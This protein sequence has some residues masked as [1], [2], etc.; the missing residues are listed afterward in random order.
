MQSKV[1]VII[2]SWGADISLLQRN[3]WIWEIMSEGERY[4]VIV[5]TNDRSVNEWCAGRGVDVVSVT[6]QEALEAESFLPYGWVSAM[7]CAQTKGPLLLLDGARLGL[8]KVAIERKL[9][10]LLCN[11]T[12]GM[13]IGPVIDHPAQSEAYYSTRI[14]DFFVLPESRVPEALEVLVGEQ[15]SPLWLSKAV[16]LDFGYF[17]VEDGPGALYSVD[18]VQGDSLQYLGGMTFATFRRIKSLGDGDAVVLYCPREGMCQRIFRC[19]ESASHSILSPV[20][21]NRSDVTLSLEKGGGIRAVMIMPEIVTQLA[22]HVY[23][24]RSTGM[25]DLG[26]VPFEIEYTKTGWH[27]SGHWGHSSED[28]GYVFH[29]YRPEDGGSVDFCE[30]VF[31]SQGL[32]K[33]DAKQSANTNG[34][35]KLAIKGRQDLPELYGLDGAFV[36]APTGHVDDFMT[37]YAEGQVKAVKLEISGESTCCP[38]IMDSECFEEE[39]SVASSS[40]SLEDA[41]NGVL[42]EYRIQNTTAVQQL[43]WNYEEEC[44]RAI[45]KQASQ[46]DS[47]WFV[48]YRC[49]FDNDVLSRAALNQRFRNMGEVRKL[50]AIR[51]KIRRFRLSVLSER[52][53][54]LIKAGKEMDILSLVAKELHA[55][56][57]DYR[58]DLSVIM[59][60][61]I[62][63]S[64]ESDEVVRLFWEATKIEHL[65]TLVHKEMGMSLGLTTD[66]NTGTLY[67]A[68]HDNGTVHE[69]SHNGEYGGVLISGLGRPKALGFYRDLVWICDFDR[70]LLV[71]VDRLGE[72]RNTYDLHILDPHFSHPVSLSICDGKAAVL[73]TNAKNQGRVL[74]YVDLDCP[75]SSIQIDISK[76]EL[77][78]DALVYGN[79]LFCLDKIAGF[80]WR[81]SLD[82]FDMSIWNT[83]PLPRPTHNL[84]GSPSG[85]F[86][87]SQEGVIQISNSGQLVVSKLLA[88]PLSEKIRL[89]RCHYHAGDDSRLYVTER[90]SCGIYVLKVGR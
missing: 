82:S 68:D 20:M 67:V 46:Y 52:L 80:V 27:A 6:I 50:H 58:T 11:G 23:A 26:I 40:D 16:P 32:W 54:A 9:E 78:S 45:M 49:G 5:A 64:P 74:S 77:C 73:T 12:P 61:C 8:D 44:S 53:P 1:T 85:I 15:D 39:M 36:F 37:A 89:A 43:L 2:L 65:Y 14:L 10:E 29:A 17:H 22:V 81:G 75:K 31:S 88:T 72:I 76:M 66:P 83:S 70:S 38:P 51:Q 3:S 60:D 87:I 48:Q 84:T 25:C 41:I 28:I 59:N 90:G 4:R 71:A 57:D 86:A 19:A 7:D 47:A 24:V 79:N 69:F 55:D 33:W 21:A 42:D 30:T 56:W 34:Q 35:T 62:K 13:S 63:S 18:Y